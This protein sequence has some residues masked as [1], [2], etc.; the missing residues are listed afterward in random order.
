MLAASG[1]VGWIPL[2]ALAGVLIATALAMVRVSAFTAVLRA[3]KGDGVTIV[4]TAVATVALDLVVAQQGL[5]GF[6]RALDGAGRLDLNLRTDADEGLDRMRQCGGCL[7]CSLAIGGLP[8]LGLDPH[9]ERDRLTRVAVL[10]RVVQQVREHLPHP[11]QVH[12][13]LARLQQVQAHGN[14]PLLRHIHVNLR[15]LPQQVL[16]NFL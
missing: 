16:G 13:D 9:G 14:L 15:H 8:A 3:T 2:P 6:H 11:V 12:R 7:A 5:R 4:L 10:R 1:L